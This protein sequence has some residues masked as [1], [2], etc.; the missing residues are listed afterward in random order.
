MCTAKP[1]TLDLAFLESATQ[2][3]NG[4][5]T[6]KGQKMVLRLRYH[7]QI[8]KLGISAWPSGISIQLATYFYT[9]KNLS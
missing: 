9:A 4:D 8:R 3:V 7:L 2:I 1:M 5:I 6:G